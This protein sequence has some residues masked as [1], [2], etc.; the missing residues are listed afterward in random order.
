MNAK[1]V[2]KHLPPSL[3]AQAAGRGRIAVKNW[4]A[5]QGEQRLEYHLDKSKFASAKE[6]AEYARSLMP[7]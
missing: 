5:R 2:N 4:V 3:H 6:M 7:P 1:Q